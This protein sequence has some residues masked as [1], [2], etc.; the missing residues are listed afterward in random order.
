MPL[1][2]TTIG[3]GEAKAERLVEANNKAVA[4]NFAARGLV[5]VE[6]A[7]QADLFRLAKAGKE[8]EVA[9]DAPEIAQDGGA[10][11]GGIGEPTGTLGGAEIIGDDEP[12]DDTAKEP[13]KPKK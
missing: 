8:V 6:I 2:V 13:A 3:E 10:S 4:R 7:S 1:Y 12:L 9:T 5:K 11:G